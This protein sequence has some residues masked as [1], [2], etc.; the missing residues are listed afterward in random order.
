MYANDDSLLLNCLAF[1]SYRFSVFLETR[2]MIT[3]SSALYYHRIK[4][5]GLPMISEWNSIC[6]YFICYSRWCI[7]RFSVTLPSAFV[8][9]SSTNNP[10]SS[11]I[12]SAT[13]VQTPI[14]FQKCL[15]KKLKLYHRFLGE[16]QHLFNIFNATRALLNGASCSMSF[17]L[18]SR[19]L[20]HHL[21]SFRLLSWKI[22]LRY[23]FHKHKLLSIAL[24]AIHS[25]A[26]W[27]TRRWSSCCR[28]KPFESKTN[29]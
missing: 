12:T 8:I 19:T 6:D 26:A 9:N 5:K 21:F 13:V 25:N 23:K 10:R 27:K 4:L 29:K 16:S 22:A 1:I 28:A 14:N 2:G 17:R 15:Q 18:K 3:T 11:Q 24:D 7:I 20:T